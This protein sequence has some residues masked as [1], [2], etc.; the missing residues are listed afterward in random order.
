L[1]RY[2]DDCIKDFY[3]NR[4][5][6]FVNKNYGPLILEGE[7]DLRNNLYYDKYMDLLRE[8]GNLDFLGSEYDDLE[9]K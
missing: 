9:T 3:D 2:E 6:I 4:D 7:K 5:K 8:G 1:N